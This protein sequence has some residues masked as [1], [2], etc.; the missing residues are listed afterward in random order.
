MALV[1][2][3]EMNSGEGETAETW[4]TCCEHRDEFGLRF[5]PSRSCQYPEHRQVYKTKN[6]PTRRIDFSISKWIK[7]TYGTLVAV[8]QGKFLL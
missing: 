6:K 4:I 3:F 8:G 1:G 2:I 7:Q 5:R